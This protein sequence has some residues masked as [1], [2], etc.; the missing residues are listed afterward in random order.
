[1]LSASY[2]GVDPMFMS[3]SSSQHYTP[4]NLL[5]YLLE[6]LNLHSDVALSRALHISHQLIVQI[7]AHQLPVAGALLMRMQEVSQLTIT[8][9]RQLMGDRRRTCRMAVSLASLQR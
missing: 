9:L 1:M 6:Q 2:F 7:R 3:P 8:E 5:S 4:E